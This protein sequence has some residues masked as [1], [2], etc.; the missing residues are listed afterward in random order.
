MFMTNKVIQ[1]LKVSV[2]SEKE[3][4]QIFYAIYPSFILTVVDL[5][6]DTGDA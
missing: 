1:V 2:T 3:K 5:R 4:L 6:R